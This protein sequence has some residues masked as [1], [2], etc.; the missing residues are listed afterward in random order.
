MLVVTN[1]VDIMTHLAARVLADFGV[2]RTRVIGS[3]T[4]LDTARFCFGSANSDVLSLR[5]NREANLAS[6]DAGFVARFSREVF[7]ADFA[8]ARELKEDV[9]IDWSDH[10]SDAFLNAF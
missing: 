9:A 10:L 6:S 1:P 3:G 7:E 4:T 2:P 5:L 8:A